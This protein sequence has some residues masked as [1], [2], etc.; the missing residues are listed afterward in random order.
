MSEN[1]VRIVPATEAEVPLILD[2][3]KGLAEYEKLGP[4]V[5]ASEDSLRRHLFGP[6]PAAEVLLA[7]ADD[8]PVGFALFFP[9]F[10]TFLGRPGIYLEDL[11]V[12]PAWR[13]RGVGRRL[14]AHLARLAVDRGAGRLEWVVLDWNKPAM[15]FY[16]R[17]GARLL[18]EWHVCRLAGESLERVAALAPR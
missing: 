15:A 17:L 10:S 16:A 12:V 13:G 4:D 1:G 2:L 3:I 5:V 9:N 6:R 18:D 14:L 11:F 7:Y 8:A